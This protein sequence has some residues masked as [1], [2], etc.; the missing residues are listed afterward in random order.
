L[1]FKEI[2]TH[3]A[4]INKK[5]TIDLYIRI[6]GEYRL[7]AAKGAQLSDEQHQQ[8]G[9]EKT[10]LYF[11]VPESADAQE[12]LDA[13]IMEILT[14]PAV[15]PRAKAGIAYSTT[16]KSIQDVFQG[17]NPKTVSELR[18]VSGKIVK[19]IQSDNRVVDDFITLTSSDPYLLMHSVKVGMYGTAMTL[20]LFKDKLEDKQIHDLS[21]AYF[22]HDIGMT[23][24]PSAI[25][26]KE[27]PYADG[28]LETICNHPVW[29][30]EKLKKAEF[31]DEDAAGIVL[32]H[33]E[34]NDGSGYPFKKTG[35][36][37]PVYARIC[38]IAD[39][40]ESLTAGKRFSESRSPFEA[41]RIM[42]VNMARDFDPDLFR[43]F[44]LLL[45]PR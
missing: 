24:V 31:E 20:S 41:L 26:N 40:F 45:G 36:E 10:R 21:M 39:S 32:Y 35:S 6:K 23:R 28:E 29:G 2:P 27:G 30:L 25:L 7:F 11:M 15:S 38:A 1:S 18:K 3:A 14:D 4:L 12:S 19:M 9:E 34:K 16:L 17:T 43:A 8:L 5:S 37:I 13:H 42:Q 44:I 22:L 33:H